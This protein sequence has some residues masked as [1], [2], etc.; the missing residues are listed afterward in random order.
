MP[1]VV[2]GTSF[3]ASNGDVYKISDFL[4]RGAFGEVYRALEVRSG[5]VIAV[6]VLPLGDLASEASKTALLNEV[7]VAEKVTHPNVVRILFVNDGSAS[8]IG[9]FV[10]MEYISGGT[11]SKVLRNQSQ[12]KTQIPLGRAVEMMIDIAQGARA[13]NEKIIHRDIKPDNILIEGQTLK[14][15]D[16]GISKFVDESTRLH[17]FKGGQH[18]AYMAPESWHNQPNTFKIDVYSIGLIFHEILTSQHPLIAKVAD[19]SNFLDWEKAHLFVPVSDIR[20]ARADAPLPV[21]Q[22][23][24]RM[25]SKKSADRP[26]WDEVLVTL[27]NPAVDSSSI[28]PSISKAVEAAVTRQKAEEEAR[29]KE[30]QRQNERQRQV[31]LYGVSCESLLAQFD[32]LIE[33]FNKSFQHGKISRDKSTF[34]TR[35]HIPHGRDIEVSFFQP[36]RSGLKIQNGELIGAGWIGFSKGRSANLVLLKRAEDDIYGDWVVCEVNVSPLVDPSRLSQF[37]IYEGMT[38]PFGFKDGQFYDQIRYATGG[39]HVFTY[40]FIKNVP[41]HFAFLLSEAC[42]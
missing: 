18:M 2:L 29:L 34:V 37:G 21:A 39:M 11:L 16:F 12:T 35:Y 8:E 42:R 23:L 32:P 22:I 19:V 41:E 26:G 40:H 15:G 6:K 38:T 5:S 30:A 1:S 10:A 13:I 3:T 7:R 20:S 36:I 17:T 25:V 31:D 28:H 24:S 9:P 4:G 14:I 27:S 33:Q